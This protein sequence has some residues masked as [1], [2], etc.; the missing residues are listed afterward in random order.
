MSKHDQLLNEIVYQI[1]DIVY[2]F[3]TKSNEII[4]TKRNQERLI[5]FR[6]KAI[7]TIN[8]MNVRSLEILAGLKD[9]AVVEER[10]QLL[11]QRNKEIIA[12]SLEVLVSAPDRSELMEDV[13]SVASST[14]TS[15]KEGLKKVEE[16]EAYQKVKE[17]T[18][19]GAKVTKENIDKVVND[20]KVQDAIKKAKDSELVEK[21]VEVSQKGYNEAKSNIDKFINDPK[22]QESTQK[23]MDKSKELV[24]DSSDFIKENAAKV[25]EWIQ[26]KKKNGENPDIEKE[27]AN[28]TSN[29]I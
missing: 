12:S 21:V 9:K 29:N 14:Y 7:E 22:V 26:D 25:N 19:K 3:Y 18:V 27:D 23:V 13:S 20:P 10:V 6:D 24:E 16:T 4:A 17:A 1:D 11:I 15:V 28:E 5:S 2:S 8:D